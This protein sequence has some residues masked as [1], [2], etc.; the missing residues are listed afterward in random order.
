MANTPS[1]GAHG[2]GDGERRSSPG[3][4][5]FKDALDACRA[6]LAELLP[7]DGDAAAA[8]SNDDIRDAVSVVAQRAA[9]QRVPPQRVLAAFKQMVTQMPHVERH[10][11]DVRGSLVRELTQL[12][13]DAYYRPDGDGH[14]P[15]RVMPPATSD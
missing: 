11:V 4:A 8:I 5:A 2:N 13:I 12:V 14:F 1:S 6:R 7:E 9:S 3:R 15:A 10:A